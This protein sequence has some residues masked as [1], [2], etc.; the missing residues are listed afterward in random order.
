[1]VSKIVLLVFSLVFQAYAQNDSFIELIKRVYKERDTATCHFINFDNDF[2][3]V[4][5]RSN[6]PIPVSIW[7]DASIPSFEFSNAI[8]VVQALEEETV[9]NDTLLERLI[10]NLEQRRDVIVSADSLVKL[11][12][13]F[14]YLS[15]KKFTRIVGLATDDDRILYG[16]FPY[17]DN[18]VQRISPHGPLSQP[19]SDLNGFSFR[20]TIMHDFPRM[21]SFKDK[22]SRLHIT[23]SSAN[24]FISFLRKHNATYQQLS[25]SRRNSSITMTDVVKATIAN[26]IDISM[27]A[28]SP[29]PSC[30]YSYPIKVVTCLMMVPVNGFVDT[31]EYFIRPFK[32]W[33]WIF[34]LIFV[35]YVTVWK[36][37]LNKF[38]QKSPDYWQSFSQTF[39]ALLLISPE[40]CITDK[41][42]LHS[43]VF[44]FTFLISNIY[45]IYFTSFMIVS[46]PIKQFDTM[47]DLIDNNV[48][49]LTTDFDKN[50]L[51]EVKAYS[52]SF[53]DLMVPVDRKLYGKALLSLNNASFAYIVGDD[54]RDFLMNIR[55]S[56]MIKPVLRTAR[57]TLNFYFICYFLHPHSPFKDILDEFIIN[58]LETGLTYK[59]DTDLVLEILRHGFKEKIYNRPEYGPQN[60]SLNLKHFKFAW[61]FY[62]IGLTMAGLVFFGELY[63][64]KFV[65]AEIQNTDARY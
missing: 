60:V 44:F 57:E 22:K 17:A 34:I 31:Q 8:L 56:W 32:S 15:E 62:V 3:A 52:K 24:I 47:Q 26:E 25:N 11:E 41:L 13:Y 33:V 43:Q 6:P 20:T 9:H 45:V 29:Q 36:V 18:K 65:S 21:F 23:G 54:K 50:H 64:I 39:T 48:K 30:G 53:L 46:I 19:L 5:F 58:C 27:N 10:E 49:I 38:L 35:F 1:M 16:Y 61:T 4:F 7:N 40:R 42:R 14:S 12:E 37:S 59:W 28:Y 2:L 63:I 55:A 51:T